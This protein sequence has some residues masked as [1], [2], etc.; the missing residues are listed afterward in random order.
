V[1]KLL[2]GEKLTLEPANLM[3]TRRHRK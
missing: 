3:R 1:A 2:S